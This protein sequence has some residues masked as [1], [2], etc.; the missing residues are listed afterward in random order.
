MTKKLIG[1]GL[2]GLAMFASVPAFATSAFER[3]LRSQGVV[4]NPYVLP[5]QQL[6]RIRESNKN[7]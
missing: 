4:S 3:E 1:A 2:V 6:H 7:R 5:S